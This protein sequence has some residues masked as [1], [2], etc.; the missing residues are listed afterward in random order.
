MVKSHHLS[1]AI[2]TKRLISKSLLIVFHTF[3]NQKYKITH[4][5]FVK[6]RKV[7]S[8]KDKN[9]SCKSRINYVIKLRVEICGDH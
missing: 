7:F 1:I 4:I 3:L 6:K 5:S 8:Y 9:N 2:V